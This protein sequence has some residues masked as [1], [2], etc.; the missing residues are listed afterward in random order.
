MGNMYLAK[1]FISTSVVPQNQFD[2]VLFRIKL[3][4][5]KRNGAIDLR[6]LNTR[7]NEQVPYF[8]FFSPFFLHLFSLSLLSF[9]FSPLLP[10]LPS[11]D[12]F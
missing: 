4:R 2:G 11:L 12:D 10:P 6:K 5:N 8:S 1:S 3:E 9:S 7:Y